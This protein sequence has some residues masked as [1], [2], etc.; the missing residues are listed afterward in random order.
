[1]DIK[2][3]PA[4]AA[5]KSGDLEKL[6]ALVA[7][8][9][10]LATAQSSR[11]HPTLLQAVVLDGKDKPNSVAMAEVLID[12]GA[13]LNEPLISARNACQTGLHDDQD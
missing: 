13:E 3:H 12:A 6:K 4:I 2:F 9:P 8:D 7:A 11:S 5:M 10:S 1:M